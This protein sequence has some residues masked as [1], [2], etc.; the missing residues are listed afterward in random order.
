MPFLG[1]LRGILGEFPGHHTNLDLLQIRYYVPR[2]PYYVEST[3]LA[4]II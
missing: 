4:T 1:P 3:Y 2:I